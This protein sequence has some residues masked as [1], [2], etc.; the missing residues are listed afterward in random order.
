[1]AKRTLDDKRND[2]LFKETQVN[3]LTGILNDLDKSSNNII[4]RTLSGNVTEQKKNQTLQEIRAE[5]SAHDTK[6]RDWLTKSVPE[7]YVAGLNGARELSARAQTD[8]DKGTTL[9]KW[10]DK[11]PEIDTDWERLRAIGGDGAGTVGDGVYFS[12]D[13]NSASDFGNV[14][15]SSLLPKGNKLV[16]LTTGRIKHAET[17]L[18][19][20]PFE[21]EALKQGIDVIEYAKRKGFDGVIFMADDGK[22]KWVGLNN[23]AVTKLKNLPP[24]KAVNRITVDE[25]K[26]D[27]NLE[28]HLKIVNSL[29]SKSYADF[30]QTMNGFVNGAD[31]FLSE[32]LKRQLRSQIAFGRL[33]GEGIPE[34]K[35]DIK[36]TIK[37]E[38]FTVLLDKGGRKWALG[39]YGEMLARTHILKANNEARVNSAS[40]LGID[41]IEVSNHNTVTPLCEQ[42]EGK[43]YSLSGKSKKYPVVPFDPDGE[44]PFHPNCKHFILLRPDLE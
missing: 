41:I 3:K 28:P 22:H 43:I 12:L 39:R 19:M 44:P 29:L 15:T 25:L 7:S 20:H 37:S 17:G 31:T 30:G 42:Y 24:P 8:I 5:V 2:Q 26:T 23:T 14:L 6:V 27:P 21:R 35:R 18:D 32:A 4:I 11:T 16:D 1:M 36:N 9:Y 40:E 13:P 34:I 10:T 33:A 38:G